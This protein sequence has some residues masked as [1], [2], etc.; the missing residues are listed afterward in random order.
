VAALGAAA[1]AF[2]AGRVVAEGQPVIGLMTKTDTNPLFV[3]M[4]EGATEAAKAN[5][6]GDQAKGQTAALGVEA[7]VEYVRG[8]RKASGDTGVTLIAATAVPGV[9]S[10]DVATGAALCWGQK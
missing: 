10:R 3:K 9:D 5:G 8:G 4:K 2:A 7:G 6:Y 1:V